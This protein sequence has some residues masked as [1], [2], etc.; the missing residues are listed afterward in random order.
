[1]ETLQQ[2]IEYI[3]MLYQ[4]DKWHSNDSKLLF[5]I[6]TSVEDCD[7][8]LINKYIDKLLTNEGYGQLLNE[9]QTHMSEMD[10]EF[11]IEKMEIG[12]MFE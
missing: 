7:N 6:G 12:E 3:Y 8:A 1:M 9:S 10:W 5:Y 4:T 2:G 11:T